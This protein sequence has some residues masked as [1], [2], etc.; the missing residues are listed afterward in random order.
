MIEVVEDAKD[1]LVQVAG[2]VLAVDVL[3]DMAAALLKG[4]VENAV[5]FKRAHTQIF[6]ERACF[7]PASS[8][9]SARPADVYDQRVFF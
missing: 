6:Q 9:G 2:T 5:S 4:T 8:S 3:T 1:L 7:L